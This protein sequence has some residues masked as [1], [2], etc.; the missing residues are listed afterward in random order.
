MVLAEIKQ[1]ERRPAQLKL[2][3]SVINDEVWY[4]DIRSLPLLQQRLGVLVSNEDGTGILEW[5]SSGNVV[6]VSGSVNP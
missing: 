1:L 6:V 5:L 3:A 2:A 4:H